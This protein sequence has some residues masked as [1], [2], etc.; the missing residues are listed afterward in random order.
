LDAM[1]ANGEFRADLM[2]RLNGVTIY[3]PPLRDRAEDIPYLLQHFLTRV[4]RDLKKPE[5]EG[6]SPDALDRLLHYSWPGNVR[7]LLSVVRQAVLKSSGTVITPEALPDEI[8]ERRGPVNRPADRPPQKLPAE[9]T[10]PSVPSPPASSSA[11][12]RELVPF[13]E[14]RLQ[15]HTTNLYAET[16]EMV[17]RYLF[18]RT[19][20]VTC[21]NQSQAAEILG[22]TRGKVRDRIASFKITLETSVEI[23]DSEAQ[24]T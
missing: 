16:M 7:E 10:R 5:I 17:E 8:Q 18:A 15:E 4:T 19:L 6:I 22:I 23:S 9:E 24:G 14:S 21:G 3:L 13:V 2:Y 1:V 20:Q 11:P 12:P